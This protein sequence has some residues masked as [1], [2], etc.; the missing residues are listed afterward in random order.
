MA[1]NTMNNSFSIVKDHLHWQMLCDNARDN[2]GDSDT[3]CTWLGQLGHSDIN[4]NNP[5]CV[6]TPK[7]AKASK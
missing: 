7:V 1:F 6:A 5:I 4:R 2:A 3:Y